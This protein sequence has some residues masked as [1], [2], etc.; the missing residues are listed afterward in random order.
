MLCVNNNFENSTKYILR[1]NPAVGLALPFE[2]HFKLLFA[3][4]QAISSAATLQ[5]APVYCIK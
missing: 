2:R 3:S 1:E 4:R 5:L